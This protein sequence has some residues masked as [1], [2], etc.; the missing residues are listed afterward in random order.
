VTA[1]DAWIADG[2]AATATYGVINTL[3]VSAVTDM[4]II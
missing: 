3:D 2:T 1:V 4:S